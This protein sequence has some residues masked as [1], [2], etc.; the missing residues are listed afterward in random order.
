MS[1]YEFN[2]RDYAEIFY[3]RKVLIILTFL[4]GA[5][6]TFALYPA[7]PPVFQSTTTVKIEDRKTVAGLLSEWI[8]YNPGDLMASQTKIIK[9]FPIIKKVALHL[10]MINERSP[11]AKIHKVVSKLQNRI[12]TK[13]IEQTNIIRITASADN[14]I[15]ARDLAKT[16]CN[17][18][19]EENLIEKTRQARGTRQFIE[20]QLSIMVDRLMVAEERLRAFEEETGEAGDVTV[21]LGK[22]GPIHN[23]IMELK[24]MLATLAQRYTI[25]NPKI[26]RVQEQ[27]ND[28]ELQLENEKKNITVP[29]GF[30]SA[31]KLDHARLSREVEINKKL[32][33]MFKEKLEE[34]RI[35]E[36]Q[37]VGGVS[38]LDP[39]VLL[40]SPVN[41][42][43][44]MNVL[45]GGIVGLLLGI[46][47][48]FILEALDTSIGTVEEV[49]NFIKLPVLGVIPSAKRDIK[50]ETIKS[51]ANIHN[52]SKRESEEIYTR[53]ITHHQPKSLV[54]EAC[55]NIRTNLKLG[56]SKKTILV[57]SVSQHEGKTTVM[58]NLGL[59]IAQTGA[60]T[61]L[62]SSDLRRPAIARSFGIKNEP[63]LTDLLSGTVDSREVFRNISD[64]I[65]GDTTLDII[66]N[67]PGLE[68]IWV[69]PS[70]KL[71][72]NPAEV[73]ESQKW[74]VLLEELRQQFDVI[75]LD[76]PPLLPVADASII[77]SRVDSVIICYES[78]KNYRGALLRGKMQLESIG[79]N[80]SGIVLNHI[81][82]KSGTTELNPY[83][84]GSGYRY[85]E[86]VQQV[87]D[88]T[89]TNGNKEV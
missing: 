31:Q 35:K 16:V 6:C 72:V 7:P 65:L 86:K 48:A 75:L 30:S 23:K 77:A 33:M 40:N 61:L 46:G 36:A 45:I 71:P 20:E 50:K 8:I 49:E 64:I 2:L 66:T 14:A 13:R 26:K 85:S 80:I 19:I 11:S 60:K 76:S 24:F 79:A 21:D 28:L 57:T 29:N 82:S 53:L 58:I 84:K 70:G 1:Y 43:G 81:K 73:L 9:G 32:Y 39:A 15:E 5:V 37:K 38:I 41:T 83:Y 78:S 69:L 3:K 67:S 25:K 68:N 34:A 89:S 18:Y 22:I 51:I 52:I 47:L 4:L 27:I 88:Q 63:G 44:S 74:K 55:R 56:P 42:Q 62:V 17:M 87:E 59:A 54:A 12:D 10:N